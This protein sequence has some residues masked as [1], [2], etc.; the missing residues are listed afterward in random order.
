MISEEREKTEKEETVDEIK[1][2]LEK[3]LADW[4]PDE[5]AAEFEFE[6]CIKSASES[7]YSQFLS[8]I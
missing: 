6:Q 3:C 7:I 5:P 2:I 4:F 8:E 1:D